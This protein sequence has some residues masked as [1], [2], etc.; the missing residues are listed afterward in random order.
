[1]SITVV[2][3]DSQEDCQWHRLQS[4]DCPSVSLAVS[5]RLKSVPLSRRKTARDRL[6]ERLSGVLLGL[7]RGCDLRKEG[8]TVTSQDNNPNNRF[9]S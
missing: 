7:T 5:H 9:D 8:V 2:G 4:V 1:M 3:F 6:N